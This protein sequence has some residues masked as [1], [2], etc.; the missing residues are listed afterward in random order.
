MHGRGDVRLYNWRP[1]TELRT[2]PARATQ[3][4]RALL[5]LTNPEVNR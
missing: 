3:L 1:L 2:D 4:L 5:A